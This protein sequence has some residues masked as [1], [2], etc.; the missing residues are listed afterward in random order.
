V[1][2]TKSEL[3]RFMAATAAG[4]LQNDV[5]DVFDIHQLAADA[6]KART[7]GH[8]ELWEAVGNDPTIELCPSVK[9]VVDFPAQPS[10]VSR[11]EARGAAVASVIPVLWECAADKI[12][13]LERRLAR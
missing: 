11:A 7:L 12:A 4:P 6:W 5:R 8:K 1:I 13:A 9:R 10:N 3:D 2:V